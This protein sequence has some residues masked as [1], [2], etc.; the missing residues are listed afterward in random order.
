MCEAEA[1]KSRALRCN[2]REF[3]VSDAAASS[4]S[5]EARLRSSA[6]LP[7]SVSFSSPA[8]SADFRVDSITR[9]S[10][11]F[12]IYYLKISFNHN[13]RNIVSQWRSHWGLHIGEFLQI[14]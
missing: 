8:S 5:T 13:H 7:K 12:R 4:A 3:A 6:I 11:H 1:S 9:I 14:H 2:V 10:L